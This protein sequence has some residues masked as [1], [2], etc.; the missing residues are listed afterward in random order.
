[1]SWER[2]EC[3]FNPQNMAWWSA[4]GQVSASSFPDKFGVHSQRLAVASQTGWKALLASHT[5]ATD[6]VNHVKLRS[7]LRRSLDRPGREIRTKNPVWVHTTVSTSSDCAPRVHSPCIHTKRLHDIPGATMF[8][9]T[10]SEFLPGLKR[11]FL[12]PEFYH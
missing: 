9:P 10:P 8:G 6:S 11:R 4:D 3:V 12:T 2:F 1:M 7:H 5:V